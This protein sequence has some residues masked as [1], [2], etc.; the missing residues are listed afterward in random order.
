MK[1]DD[2]LVGVREEDIMNYYTYEEKKEEAL[3]ILNNKEISEEEREE[4]FKEYSEKY[5]DDV[6]D[7][8][9]LFMENKDA[10]KRIEGYTTK[11]GIFR[12]KKRKVS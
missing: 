12:R 11:N 9:K 4:L 6:Y 10:R 1:D 2:E 3:K 7:K 5:G 8:L